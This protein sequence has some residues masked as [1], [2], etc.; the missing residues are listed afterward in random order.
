M[1][2]NPKK[3]KE[4]RVC[5][6]RETPV[7][8]PLLIDGHSLEVVRSHKVLGLVIQNDLKWNEH[9]ETVVAKAVHILRRGGVPREDLLSTYIALVRSVLEYCCVVWHHA[10]P[11]YLS[12]ELER[13]QKLALGFILTDSPYG[14]ALVRLGCPS[15]EK[16]REQLCLNTLKRIE[17]R[18]PLS[19]YIPMTRSKTNDYELRN[20][21][22]LTTIKC[23]TERYRHSFFPSTVAVLNSNIKSITTLS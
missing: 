2:L 19:K 10:L 23:R 8:P 20:S 21:D 17:K 12:N 1:K 15:L 18:G 14:E 22:T 11:S 13:V 6:L 3:C 16:K 5:F 9:I 7:L 4:L